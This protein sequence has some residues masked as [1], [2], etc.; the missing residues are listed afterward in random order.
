MLA[1]YIAR[2]VFTIL[3]LLS[4]FDNIFQFMTLNLFLAY[5]PFELCFLLRLFQPR[6][7]IEWPLFIVFV[8]IFI[9]MV[10]NTFYMIT[11]LIHLK[12]FIFNFYAGLN[13]KEWIYFTYL[14]SGVLLALYCLMVMFLEVR[15]F[16][17]Y[18]WLN[19]SFIFVM[20]CLNGLGIYVGRFLRLHSVYLINE[21]MRIIYKFI[22]AIDGNAIIFVSLM[23]AL[24]VLLYLFMKGVRSFNSI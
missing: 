20:M 24:Q 5:V 10:P 18:K 19:R 17:G 13:L 15:L 2:G 3:F 11:D 4:L 1:R 23:V 21:P 12:Q 22:S 14:I 7:K 8:L 9:T 16:T 6:R